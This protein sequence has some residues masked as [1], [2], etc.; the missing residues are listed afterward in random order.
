MSTLTVAMETETTEAWQIREALA[1]QMSTMLLPRINGWETDLGMA[2]TVV[3]DWRH[4][5]TSSFQ[6]RPSPLIGP[7][8]V[9]AVARL[10]YFGWQHFHNLP[11]VGTMVNDRPTLQSW[12]WE[13]FQDFSNSPIPSVIGGVENHPI[14]LLLMQAKVG[15]R[16]GQIIG[17]PGQGTHSY[18]DAPNNWESD[19]AVDIALPNRT[20]I[21]AIADGVICSHCGFGP[22][23]GGSRFKGERF[24]LNYGSSHQAFY[25]HLSQLLIRPGERVKAGQVIGYS[26][27]A[28]GV[29][30]LHLATDKFDPLKIATAR[31]IKPY[32]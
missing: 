21:L 31:R 17:R 19:H 30:H 4:F 8:P 12:P 5:G 32:R 9:D 20:P 29:Y 22:Q 27:D 13:T 2:H 3:P 6:F 23:S 7:T 1:V 10:D 26:G 18:T 15:P 14:D 11:D 25:G 24:T 28:N 16:K